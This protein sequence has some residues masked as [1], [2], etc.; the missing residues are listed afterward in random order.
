MNSSL[1]NKIIA[2]MGGGAIA[3]AAA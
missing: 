2:A 1:R 3:I